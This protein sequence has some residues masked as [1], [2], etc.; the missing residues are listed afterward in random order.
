MLVGM[1]VETVGFFDIHVCLGFPFG[2]S[3][4]HSLLFSVV[5]SSYAS[6]SLSQCPPLF[7][8]YSFLFCILFVFLFR[9]FPPFSV[10]LGF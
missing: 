5:C 1:K 7:S 8:L 10:C 2:L 9:R 3:P 6:R 4:P